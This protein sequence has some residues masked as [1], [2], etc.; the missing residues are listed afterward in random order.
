MV[1]TV[2]VLP[3]TGVVCFAHFANVSVQCRRAIQQQLRNGAW[4]T[5]DIADCSEAVFSILEDRQIKKNS[6][7]L[8]TWQWVSST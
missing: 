8:P 2:P 4:G 7:Y 3:L 6:Q 5:E 1:K